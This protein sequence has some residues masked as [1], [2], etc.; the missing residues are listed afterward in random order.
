MGRASH[1]SPGPTLSP[2]HRPAARA[3]LASTPINR[4]C[5]R[6]MRFVTK[7]S[8]CIRYMYVYLIAGTLDGRVVLLT[9][10]L[11]LH[12]ELS[13]D[14]SRNLHKGEIVNIK[15]FCDWAIM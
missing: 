12:K 13:V 15:L 9:G 1:W 10:S 14:Q 4:A 11:F 6:T 7:V 8:H 2:G 5:W 3:D